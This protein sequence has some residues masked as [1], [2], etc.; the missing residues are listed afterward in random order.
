MAIFGLFLALFEIAH[1]K[2]D[3][4]RWL[5][6]VNQRCKFQNAYFLGKNGHFFGLRLQG[7]SLEYLSEAKKFFFLKSSNVYLAGHIVSLATLARLHHQA[8][9]Q[10]FFFENFKNM[11]KNANMRA[12]TLAIWSGLGYLR[13][14]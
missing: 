1:L 2:E 4:F 10:I 14:F 12:A 7:Y 9:G 13:M 3:V 8:L 11:P 5:V 6:Y